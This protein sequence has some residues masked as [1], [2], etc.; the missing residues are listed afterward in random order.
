MGIPDTV[1]VAVFMVSREKEKKKKNP[2]SSNGEVRFKTLR[3]LQSSP[4][5]NHSFI[6]Y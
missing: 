1:T 6:P 5:E 4:E 2:Q 3:M